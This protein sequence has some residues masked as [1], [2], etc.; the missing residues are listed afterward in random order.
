VKACPDYKNPALNQLL[1]GSGLLLIPSLTKL[2]SKPICWGK[3]FPSAVFYITLML[4]FTAVMRRTCSY[5]LYPGRRWKIAASSALTME[6]ENHPPLL[7]ST[8][9]SN[10]LTRFEKNLLLQ[11]DI[12][13]SGRRVICR[14]LFHNVFSSP[15]SPVDY[16]LFLKYLYLPS[17]HSF[18]SFIHS[19]LNVHVCSPSSPIFLLCASISAWTPVIVI[20]ITTSSFH[21]LFISI[22]NFLFSTC[23]NSSLLTTMFSC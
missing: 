1:L 21:F 10:K 4:Q 17:V 16:I 7:F 8:L 23:N 15:V 3:A 14:F 18:C 9:A 11:K 20:I 12:K 2:P 22:S 5:S 13:E 6:V 19:Y